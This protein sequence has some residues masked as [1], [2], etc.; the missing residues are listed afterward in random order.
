MYFFSDQGGTYIREVNAATGNISL[1]AGNGSMA[2]GDGGAATSAGVGNIYGICVDGFGDIYINDIS[3]ACRKINMSTGIITTVAGSDAI[4][5]Y[6]GEGTNSLLTWFNFPHGVYVD[7]TGNIYIADQENN[8]IRKAIQLT[9]GP[10]LAYGKGQY[11]YPC[12]GVP[13]TVNN[14]LAIGNMNIGQVETWTVISAPANGTLIGFP[15]TMLSKGTD[16]LAIPS[17]LSYK[18][19]TGYLGA[20]SFRVRVSNGMLSDTMTIYVSVNTTSAIAITSPSSVCTGE[21]ISL[22]AMVFGGTWTVTNSN[23]Y[24]S[25]GELI[26]YS[27]GLDTIIYSVPDECAATSVVTVNVSPNAGTIYGISDVCIGALTTL[28][29]PISGGHGVQ[30]PPLYLSMPQQELL[31]VYLPVR[32]ISF[33][34]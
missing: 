27:N 4:D 20:D 34:L 15:Y 1:I 3:C 25:S 29:D 6:N 8:R 23:A 11:I 9:S 21:G 22:T 32:R 10:L 2:S 18:S 26:G 7:G 28:T 33:I 31:Q 24:I 30:I 5:G 12:S 14:L 16:S 19:S 17:G 13:L